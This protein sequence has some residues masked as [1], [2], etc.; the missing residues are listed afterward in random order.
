MKEFKFAVTFLYGLKSAKPEL[1][2]GTKCYFS[3][4]KSCR[5]REVSGNSSGGR[6]TRPKTSP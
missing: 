4:E 1:M 3:E 2:T 5:I 6:R